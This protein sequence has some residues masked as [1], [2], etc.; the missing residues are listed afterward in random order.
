MWHGSGP[1]IT[2]KADFSPED[3]PNRK[4]KR[5]IFQQ[6]N[7]Q[8]L[9]AVSGFGYLGWAPKTSWSVYRDPGLKHNP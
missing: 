7:F 9:L 8:T 1:K 3:G 2:N 5:I 6:L 4:G